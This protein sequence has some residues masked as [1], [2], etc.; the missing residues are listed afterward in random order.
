MWQQHI[1]N[2]IL[3]N[4]FY[5]FYQCLIMYEVRL[6]GMSG[7]LINIQLEILIVH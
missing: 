5:Y 7:F 6:P 2:Y 4:S 1:K 3:G